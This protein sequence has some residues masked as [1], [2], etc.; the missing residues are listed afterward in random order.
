MGM[1]KGMKIAIGIILVIA[2]LACAFFLYRSI[3]GDT[4][5]TPAPSQ[6]PLPLPTLAP[7]VTP[8]PTQPAAT[9]AGGGTTFNGQ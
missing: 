4:N 8:T 7:A 6:T 1:R 9:D 3:L 2:I 5:K